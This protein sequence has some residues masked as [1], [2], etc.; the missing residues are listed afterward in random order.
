M[1]RPQYKIGDKVVVLSA[2]TPAQRDIDGSSLRALIGKVITVYNIQ[3]D[4]GYNDDFFPH[5]RCFVYEYAERREGEPRYIPECLLA[6]AEADAGWSK[7][8]LILMQ[9]YGEL[10]RIRLIMSENSAVGQDI[11]ATDKDVNSYNPFFNKKH[12]FTKYNGIK[13]S[14]KDF[15]EKVENAK[16]DNTN[17]T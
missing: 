9:I 17:N 5:G 1:P 8:E 2:T 10:N 15:Y 16:G 13:N 14:K 11:L 3:E 6:L 4:S 12:L 7:R